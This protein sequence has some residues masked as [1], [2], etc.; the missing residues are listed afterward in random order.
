MYKLYKYMYIYTYIG[1]YINM[2]V[3]IGTFNKA[4]EIFSCVLVVGERSVF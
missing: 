3:Y 2:Y 4:F 1:V